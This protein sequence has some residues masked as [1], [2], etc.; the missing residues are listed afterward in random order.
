[1]RLYDIVSPDGTRFFAV[2]TVVNLSLQYTEL[3]PICMIMEYV[4]H[5]MWGILQY[6]R[7]Q[8]LAM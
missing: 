2:L 1:M 6:A 8:K 4:E 7:D 3:K 5:D